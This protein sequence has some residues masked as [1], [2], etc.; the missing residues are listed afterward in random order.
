[1]RRILLVSLAAIASVLVPAPRA[2]AELPP[3]ISREVL[4]GNPDRASPRL[5]PDGKLL[6]YLKADDRNEQQSVVYRR[7][8]QIQISRLWN[9]WVITSAPSRP[10]ILWPLRGSPRPPDE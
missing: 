10:T 9:L 3:L 2:G 5:S 6:G 4:F 8:T 7:G 1:M